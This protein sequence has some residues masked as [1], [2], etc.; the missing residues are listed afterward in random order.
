[1]AKIAGF[2]TGS[3][4]T[5][6]LILLVIGLPE[7]GAPGAPV[8]EPDAAIELAPVPAPAAAPIA[9]AEPE[10]KPAAEPEAEPEAAPEAVVAA[11]PQQPSEP[12][13]PPAQWHAF[14]SPFSSRIAADGFVRRLESVTGFDYRVVKVENG[15]YEVAFA[16]ADEQDRDAMLSTIAAATGLEL[17]ES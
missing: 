8:D 3:A 4:I 2:L 13:P 11:L 17:P 1:M 15:V 5:I 12:A 10:P 7:L 6:V 9:A 16:Y 14:W